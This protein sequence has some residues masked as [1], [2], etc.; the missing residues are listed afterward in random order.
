[1]GGQKGVARGVEFLTG[2]GQGENRV[3]SWKFRVEGEELRNGRVRQSYFG[4]NDG[5]GMTD[6]A[7][8]DTDVRDGAEWAEVGSV[9]VM[10]V[11]FIRSIVSILSK[12]FLT[13][14]T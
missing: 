2:N 3:K 11:C 1:V 4:W 8:D 6:S 5:E 13:G 9:G 12:S 14:F 10:G 7:T